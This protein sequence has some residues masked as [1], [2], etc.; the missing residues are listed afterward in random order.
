MLSAELLGNGHE[1]HSLYFYNFSSCQIKPEWNIIT[2]KEE[3]F[4][5]ATDLHSHISSLNHVQK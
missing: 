4:L 5:S 2:R 1:L 3:A